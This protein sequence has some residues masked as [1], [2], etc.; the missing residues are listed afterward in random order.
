MITLGT[1]YNYYFIGDKFVKQI[2]NGE[3]NIL[4]FN[5]TLDY[6]TL[7][8]DSQIKSYK[9]NFDTGYFDPAT[10]DNGYININA[11]ISKMN[12]S[13]GSWVPNSTGQILRIEFTDIS[14][15]QIIT[16]YNIGITSRTN[17]RCN[18]YSYVTK[19]GLVEQT[20]NWDTYV[21]APFNF[22]L[23]SYDFT[24]NKYV[25]NLLSGRD[26]SPSLISYEISTPYNG[27]LANIKSM[28]TSSTSRF[29]LRDITIQR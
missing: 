3:Q 16:T 10:G 11:P 2:Y 12:V 13:V 20:A 15:Q 19:N 26:Y 6:Q 25:L 8:T 9:Y 17:I 21:D 24:N 22:N 7:P 14:T 4:G 23:F 27:C 1:N 18:Y 28:W 5:T 29:S